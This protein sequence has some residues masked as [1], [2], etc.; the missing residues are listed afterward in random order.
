MKI[1]RSQSVFWTEHYK[2]TA[3]VSEMRHLN[4]LFH[5]RCVWLVIQAG[6]YYTTT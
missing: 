1:T 4:K 5:A 6:R 2:E 3:E